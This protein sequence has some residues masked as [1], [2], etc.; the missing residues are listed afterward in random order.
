[1]KKSYHSMA[2]PTKL[3]PRTLRCSAGVGATAPAGGVGEWG[4]SAAGATGWF[5]GK[6][7]NLSRIW[8]R[9]VGRGRRAVI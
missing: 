9:G 5:E 8:S 3:A 1:M 2:V 7:R 4:V 6:D